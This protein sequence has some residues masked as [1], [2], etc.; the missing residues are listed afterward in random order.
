MKSNFELIYA[1][2]KR[3]P[4]GKVA[5]Y[6][7]VARL[8]GLPRHARQVGFALAALPEGANVPWQRVVNAGG[9]VSAREHPNSRERQRALLER[10]KV[11]FDERGRIALE[12]SGWRA[13]PRAKRPTR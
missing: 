2:I 9:K 11:V 13:K 10:E 7:Q 12:T 3:I 4:K 8:A 5:T 6:G 1:V